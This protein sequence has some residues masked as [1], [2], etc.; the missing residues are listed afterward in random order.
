MPEPLTE[1]AQLI[2]ARLRRRGETVAVAESAAG[3]LI[4]ASLVAVPGASSFFVGGAVIYTATAREVL[5]ADAV[6]E[7]V[8]AETEGFARYLAASG[9]RRLRATWGVGETGAA[10]PSPS[11]Y[12]DPA[13]QAWVA[14][15]GP[16][17]AATQVHTGAADR[18]ANMAAFALAA[19]EL[20]AAALTGP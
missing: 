7:G 16:A 17:G 4:A 12:G 8:R 2:G 19:L 20:L 13:G 1:V 9:A 6:A 18:P 11:P 3:G 5:L 15:A 10:G 14:V